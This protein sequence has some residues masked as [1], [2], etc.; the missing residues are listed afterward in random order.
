MQIYNLKSFLYYNVPLR[1]THCALSVFLSLSLTLGLFVE[2]VRMLAKVFL[3]FWF[4][5]CRILS[6]PLSDVSFV[7]RW[8]IDFIYWPCQHGVMD[9]RQ[10]QDEK[11]GQS[12]VVSHFQR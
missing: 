11:G 7:S 1:S 5:Y 6:H 3:L 9:G 4:S 12:F 10:R 8:G 2:D